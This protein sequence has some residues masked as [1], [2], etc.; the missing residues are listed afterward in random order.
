MSARELTWATLLAMPEE[1][2]SSFW[3]ALVARWQDNAGREADADIEFDS[4][5]DRQWWE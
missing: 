2:Q 3:R 4:Q 1:Q 5:D